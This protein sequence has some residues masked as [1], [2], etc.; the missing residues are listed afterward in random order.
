MS[1]AGTRIHSTNAHR[2]GPPSFGGELCLLY[3]IL[4]LEGGDGN[5]PSHLV[6]KTSICSYR[7]TP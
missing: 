1:K 2:A 3:A 6:S 4:N 7:F 5:A